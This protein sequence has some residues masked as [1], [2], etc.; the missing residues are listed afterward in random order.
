MKV[1][2]DIH[3]HTLFSSC[4]YDP[5]ATMEAFVKK[6]KELGH[7]TLGIA[8]H[9]WDENV[10]GASHWYK[11][12]TVNYVLE[13]KYALDAVDTTG[14]KVLFGV[15][16]EYSALSDTLAITPETAKQFDYVLVPHTHTHMRNFVIAEPPAVAA[17]RKDV[18]DAVAAA[19]PQFNEAQIKKMVGA[20]GHGDLYP[21]TKDRFDLPEYIADFCLDSFEKMLANPRF[22]EL[23]KTVPTMVAHPFSPGEST[24]VFLPSVALLTSGVRR[25]R[26]TDL[27]ARAAAMGLTF[28]INMGSFRAPENDFAN[29]PMVEVMKIA[30]AQGIKFGCSTDAHAVN[31]LA[32]IRK[33]DLVTSAIGITEADL[34]DAIV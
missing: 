21:L 17:Y 19:L 28:D 6:A 9:M 8:N 31:D 30:K 26:L 7:T 13:S 4:C 25:A 16:V 20:L 1:T 3:N 2:H 11:G 34:W 23:S 27:C 24:D 14:L 12:Q 10:P 29:D 15:E 32:G 5:A 22:I 18:T 33:A